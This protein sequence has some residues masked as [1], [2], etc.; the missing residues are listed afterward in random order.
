MSLVAA[1][2]SN[3]DQWPYIIVSYVVTLGG[4]AA[5]VVHLLRRARR[6]ARRVPP[7]E[8]PWT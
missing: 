3:S 2:M 4:V 1:T 8:R 5:Y 7:K 6:S